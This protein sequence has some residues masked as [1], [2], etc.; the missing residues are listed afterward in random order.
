MKRKIFSYIYSNYHLLC[1][2]VIAILLLRLMMII[3][4]SDSIVSQSEASDVALYF[5]KKMCHCILSWNGAKLSEPVPYYS[6]EDSNL[7]IAYEY[8]VLSEGN[9]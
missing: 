9:L 4:S 6:V 3:S 2:L 7:V 5:M 8:T 1:T